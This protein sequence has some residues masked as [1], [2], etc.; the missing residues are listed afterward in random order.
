MP[1]ADKTEEIT[2]LFQLLQH[3]QE[4]DAT[5]RTK[6]FLRDIL[7]SPLN[8]KEWQSLLD[9]TRY[10]FDTNNIDGLSTI[11]PNILLQL[12]ASEYSSS[13]HFLQELSEQL[14]EDH[15]YFLWPAIVNEIV[16]VGLTR[17]PKAYMALSAKAA[18]IPPKEMMALSKNL[19]QLDTFQEKLIAQ[20]VFLPTHKPSFL[21]FSFLLTTPLRQQLL[22]SITPL[23]QK[24]PPG[25]LGEA[26]LPF[27]DISEGQHAKFIQNYLANVHL[28]TPPQVLQKFVGELLITHLPG[29]PEDRREEPWVSKAIRACAKLRVDGIYEM[30]S[31]ITNSKKMLF[32]YD[33]PTECRAAAE[34]T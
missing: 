12:R 20:S 21:L 7:S 17:K 1:L 13:L 16:A 27:I 11:L 22:A 18:S 10:F 31:S 15:Y 3:E 32:L 8:Q 9:A 34:E 14:T 23:L 4:D 19:V 2:V 5:Q 29:L 30:L 25:W 26:A 24:H 6:F 33:W 28:A